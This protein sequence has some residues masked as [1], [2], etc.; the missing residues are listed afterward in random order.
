MGDHSL[1]AQQAETS[2]I[3][4]STAS[5]AGAG[6][7][8]LEYS[9]LAVAVTE[10]ALHTVRY[11]NPAFCQLIGT[12][13]EELV[14]RPVAD[15]L[16]ARHAEYIRSRLD[17]VYES[18]ATDNA[19]NL[20]ATGTEGDAG[21]AYT[22]WPIKSGGRPAGL[23][24]TVRETSGGSAY[25]LRDANRQ[26]LMAGLEAQDQ[27]REAHEEL[28]LQREIER[29]KQNILADV[30]HDLK[31]PLTTIKGFTQLLQR[32]LDRDAAPDLARLREDL[33]HIDTT[34]RHMVT[35]ID[36]LLAR[37]HRR[38]EPTLPYL[39]LTALVT[40]IVSM[41]QETRKDR[42]IT[43]QPEAGA[44]E[45]QW[46]ASE[47]ERMLG[48]LLSNAVKYS[49]G[50][51]R[52]DVRLSREDGGSGPNVLLAV[53]DHGIGIPSDDLARVFV[54]HFRGSN[55]GSIAGSGIGL[56]GVQEIV[57]RYGGAVWA[58]SVPDHGTAVT[59]RLPLR[60][61]PDA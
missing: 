32:R 43:F 42:L 59:V 58:E 56:A 4:A 20:L 27:A 11:T 40:R 28:A 18:G 6:Y 29:R 50:G 55:V 49:P 17:Q 19:A 24:V 9:P 61:P 7:S 37:H 23:V 44:V 25:E 30:A 48:N 52:I 13:A 12:S 38:L 60:L 53:Q 51:G 35:Q 10:G 15:V 39:E 31:T 54:R 34:V 16:P 41:H 14:G 26:L 21:T 57:E 22:V 8:V 47:I 33:G 3:E 36:E 5:N 45:G 46:D 2:V 1:A